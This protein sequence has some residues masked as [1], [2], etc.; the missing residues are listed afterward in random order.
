MDVIRLHGLKLDT[1]IGTCAWERRIRQTVSLDLDMGVD[2]K[3]AAASD[4]LADTIDYSMVAQRLG[5]FVSAAEFKLI[6]TLA[7]G[8]A[9]IVITEFGAAQLRLTVHKPG[10]VRDAADVALCIERSRTDYA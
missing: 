6:E 10:A 2:A 1:V 9:R 4:G 5:E 3:P 7:E 8:C